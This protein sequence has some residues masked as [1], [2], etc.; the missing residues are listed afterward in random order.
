MSW[1]HEIKESI[2]YS[3]AKNGAPLVGATCIK[4]QL[5]DT[6]EEFVRQCF[7]QFMVD[8]YK[9]APS[10]LKLEY[11]MRAGSDLTIRADVFWS[12]GANNPQ[13]IA[14]IKQGDLAK[15][16]K[17]IEQLKSYMLLTQTNIG[18][19]ADMEKMT[20]FQLLEG[21][22]KIISVKKYFSDHKETLLRELRWLKCRSCKHVWSMDKSIK[23][24]GSCPVC[25]W[26]ILNRHKKNHNN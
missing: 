25:G 20:W 23:M 22:L 5:R 2:V 1:T 13:F 10:N 6:P 14:E 16:S 11:P 8:R 18:C 9:C 15:K 26:S 3:R 7:I 17:S 12:K 24:D 19:L 4:K 21:T